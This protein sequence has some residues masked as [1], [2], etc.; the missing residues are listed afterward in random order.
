MTT[1]AKA[2]DPCILVIFGAAGDLTRRLLVP[3]LYNLKRDGL[4]PDEFAMVGVART[5]KDDESFRRDLGE[6]LRRF[7][8]SSVKKQDWQWLCER[9]NYL[10]GELHDPS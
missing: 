7:K 4:L 9:F 5:D 8:K 6:S 10:R 1:H 2:G 3:A